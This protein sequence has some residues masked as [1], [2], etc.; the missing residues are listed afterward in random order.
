MNVKFLGPYFSYP[1]VQTV[2]KKTTYKASF[3]VFERIHD[4]FKNIKPNSVVRGAAYMWGSHTPKYWEGHEHTPIV[5]ADTLIKKSTVAD[6]QMVLDNYSAENHKESV[7]ELQEAIGDNL[8]IDN[9]KGANDPDARTLYQQ[10]KLGG[11]KFNLKRQP[12]N[13]KRMFANLAR[14]K[15][16]MKK[17][18]MHDKFF[19]FSDLSHIGSNTIMIGSANLNYTQYFQY[20]DIL[21]VQGSEALYKQFQIHWKNIKFAIQNR[22]RGGEYV[23]KETQAY[24]VRSNEANIPSDPK[25]QAYFYPRRTCPLRQEMKRWAEE[26]DND[27]TIH[28][29]MSFFT[30]KSLANLLGKIH[31]KSA[32]MRILLGNEPAN[33]L[34]TSRLHSYNIPTMTIKNDDWKGRMHHKFV[35]YEKGDKTITWMGSYNFTHAALS[36]NDETIVRTEDKVVHKKYKDQFNKIWYHHGLDLRGTK[37]M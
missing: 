32:R 29:A 31:D 16:D 20:N 23:A 22:L 19:L 1:E 8:T 35:L 6:V 37:I 28:V 4:L 3:E 12:K 34:T 5:I 30:Q 13:H 21:V 26:A 7:D 9:R 11:G 10:L 27:T 15:K 24:L 2:D 18:Y 17:G 33:V 14:L 25:V 36:K